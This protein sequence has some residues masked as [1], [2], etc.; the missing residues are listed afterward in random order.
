MSAIFVQAQPQVVISEY[1]NAS[2]PNSE[3]TELL[4]TG[5]NVN[6][7][8]YVLRDNSQDADSWRP[9]IKFLDI[10]LWKNL[11]RG[12]IIIINHRDD[13]T[14]GS[15]DD[16]TDGFISV[17]ALNMKY[18]DHLEPGLST[19]MNLNVT[20]EMMQLSDNNG[21]NVHTIGHMG[22]PSQDF[23]DI[24]G[25]KLC[26]RGTIN[27][28]SS[29]QIVPGANITDYDGGFDLSG[30]KIL[31][32]LAATKGFPNKAPSKPEVN[33][34]FW[35][36]LRQP[37]ANPIINVSVPNAEKDSIV[38]SWT[39]S[40][41]D[42]DNI[43]GYF[44]VRY[45]AT[46][47]NSVPIDS[48]IYNVGD[49]LGNGTVVGIVKS[50]TSTRFAD[51]Y[52]GIE[53]GKTFTYRIFVYRYENDNS[54]YDKNATSI[55]ENARGR[56]F[57]DD[58]SQMK[59]IVVKIDDVPDFQIVSK[60]GLSKFCSGDEVEL[61]ANPANWSTSDYDV[62]W[63]L[64]INEVGSGATLKIKPP[65]GKNSYTLEI[66]NKKSKC[67]KNITF[68]VEIL[69][70]P[71]AFVKVNTKSIQ[72]DTTI[73]ICNG[74]TVDAEGYY[75]AQ[76]APTLKWTRNNTDF[77][78]S[79]KITINSAGVYRFITSIGGSSCPDTAYTV[80]VID[81]SI[82]FS[83]DKNTLDFDYPTNDVQTLTINNPDDFDICINE[84]E[85]TIDNQFF[86]ISEPI[87]DAQNPCYLVPAKGSLELKI[88]Y[89]PANFG[90]HSG[91][92]TINIKC[93]DLQK[94]VLNGTFLNV[95][96]TILQV[97]PTIVD[98][99][100]LVIDC[101]PDFTQVIKMN[102][103]GSNK[104]L[105]KTP[106]FV[107]NYFEIV[108][109]PNVPYDI[110]SETLAK[111]ALKDIYKNDDGIYNDTLLLH[112]NNDI[113]GILD[114]VLKVPIKL[115]L[116]DVN[117]E[118]ET[119]KI[120]FSD[121]AKCTSEQFFNLK[122]KNTGSAK[123]KI[124]KKK[125]NPKTEILN[126]LELLPGD[127]D[128]IQLQFDFTDVNQI[129]MFISI[130]EPCLI[131]TSVIS[132]IPPKED[133]SI[134]LIKDTVDF[135]AIN[136]CKDV[137]PLAAQIKV[138]GK[139]II[140]GEVINSGK[141]FK[142]LT[143]KK[144]EPLI[145]ST[146]SLIFEV[147]PGANGPFLDSLQFYIEPCHELITIYVKGLRYGPEMPI[148]DLASNVLDF[149]SAEVGIN[150][151]MTFKIINPNK[152][153]KITIKNASLIAP[154]RIIKPASFP[155]EIPAD[156]EIEFEVEFNRSNAG[157]FSGNILFDIFEPCDFS[158]F[159]ISILG[160]AVNNTKVYEL[161]ITIDKNFKPA[162]D[163]IFRIPIEFKMLDNSTF[164]EMDIRKV[165]IYLDYNPNV[166][167]IRKVYKGYDNGNSNWISFPIYTEETLGKY[168]IS[169]DVLNAE[170][171][172]SGEMIYLQ[173]KA[174]LGNSVSTSIVFDSVVIKAGNKF[175][176]NTE[177]GFVV[178]TG[179][180]ELP[181]RL[182]ELGKSPSI[183]VS[184]SNP[185]DESSKIEI[186]VIADH[187]TTVMMYNSAGDEVSRI[188][189]QYIKPGTYEYEISTKSLSNG[190]YYIKMQSGLFAKTVKILVK[191]K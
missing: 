8:G 132:V 73:Y 4:I 97:N 28:S 108:Q 22:S 143:I 76:S 120:D 78:T 75:L 72:R 56:A 166:I 169:F 83:L 58:I 17:A 136:V 20:R 84:S 55:A 34:L 100:T 1:I 37:D 129:D 125:L 77:S 81:K 163:K 109:F 150:Q 113:N 44:I 98:Y 188:L 21:N 35:R 40:S 71:E 121:K 69:E 5:D 144:G 88:K 96:K 6:L 90:D 152:I 146:G 39:V 119:N 157:D 182:L 122:I 82:V 91:N 94:V 93:S 43:Q 42:D 51:K 31:G 130:D 189:Y 54:R 52:P 10:P 164:K 9:G 154:F 41:A 177:D 141:E 138:N 184:G 171:L 175:N 53:C 87:I 14:F 181:D 60:S 131:E 178:V 59:E 142:C 64:G 80:T 165:E 89:T 161:G 162:V 139:G 107:N 172:V 18:F 112:Y 191:R 33:Q 168:K 19:S 47:D 92:F 46:P 156:G 66:T 36:Q 117:Y 145:Q 65:K 126:D 68:E 99:K 61:T 173:T 158:N 45:D 103:V 15:D 101:S 70:K 57:L 167:E 3:A 183:K 12:T 111:I 74:E 149:G 185:A 135:D 174:L 2:S 110:N 118:F 190:A 147:L 134:T 67:S 124:N 115:E 13:D 63:K 180:C 155:I 159:K 114:T 24:I 95:G 106:T 23:T 104:I 30:S 16:K 187:I 11:R 50:F 49:N 153:D 116:L 186:S 176:V 170:K 127:E 151:I 160:S 62:K 179:V 38:L 123:F 85:I 7:N 86:T 148:S 140:I 128:I 133:L 79:S 29:V 105:L 26:Y 137:L 102:K 32:D 48:K 25:Y 27:Q